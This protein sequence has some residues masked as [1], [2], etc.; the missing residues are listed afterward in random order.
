[1]AN[2]R[3]RNEPAAVPAD[4]TTA[5]GFMNKAIKAVKETVDALRD[6]ISRAQK[7]RRELEVALLG[8]ADLRDRVRALREAF[9]RH[10]L[11]VWGARVTSW[12]G[13]MSSPLADDGRPW[14]FSTDYLPVMADFG[15]IC[16]ADPELAERMLT[17]ILRKSIAAAGRPQGPPLAERRALIAA[18]QAEIEDLE[19]QEEAYVD[20]AIANGVV[21]AHRQEVVE[22]RL[23]QARRS[24]QESRRRAV[25]RLPERQAAIDARERRKSKEVVEPRT[26]RS[27][28]LS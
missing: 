6:R 10:W 17:A 8:D 7:G 22:R 3:T 2:Q 24:E 16:V 14:R 25:E 27:S 26:G 23:N 9:E 28:Y 12:K 11:S 1:M 20:E 21:I 13:G 18:L 5:S 4:V 19:R 15:A